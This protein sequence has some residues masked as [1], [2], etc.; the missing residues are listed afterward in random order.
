MNSTEVLAA[1]VAEK[2]MYHELQKAGGAKISKP[3]E[4]AAAEK[5]WI[6]A[7]G[8]LKYEIEYFMGNHTIQPRK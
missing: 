4:Y 3:K 8:I 2:Y 5:N 7:K 1:Q 6:H